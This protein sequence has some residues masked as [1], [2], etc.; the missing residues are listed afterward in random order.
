MHVSIQLV[1]RGCRGCGSLDIFGNHCSGGRWLLLLSTA[2]DPDH[3]MR[4]AALQL[5]LARRLRLRAGLL[6]GAADRLLAQ[7]YLRP[8]DRHLHL[9]L[10]WA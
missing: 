5:L 3:P 6:H 1:G 4:G 7:W 10:L 8:S 9:A 2:S